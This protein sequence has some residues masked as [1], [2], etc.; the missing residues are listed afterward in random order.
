MPK[1]VVLAPPNHLTLWITLL[2]KMLGMFEISFFYKAIL[3]LGCWPTFAV[4]KSTRSN[5]D[6]KLSNELC[7]MLHH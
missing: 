5:P 2:K 6:D 1:L 3:M 4:K 7:T